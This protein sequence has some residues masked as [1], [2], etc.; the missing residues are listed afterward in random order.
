MYVSYFCKSRTDTNFIF[1]F[2]CYFSTIPLLQGAFLSYVTAVD[3]DCGGKAKLTYTLENV[4]PE[5]GSD[6]FTINND[7]DINRGTITA[8]KDL[9]NEWGKY[10]INVSVSG[11]IK[12][13]RFVAFPATAY[14]EV[15]S[16]YQPGQMVER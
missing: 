16:G 11:N 3:E 12:Q 10:S 7:A 14:D 1:D 15:F 2:Q 6:L 9:E 13:M 5:K 4:E 8:K